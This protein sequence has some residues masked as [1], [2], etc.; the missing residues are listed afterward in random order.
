[1]RP[2]YYLTQQLAVEGVLHARNGGDYIL[3]G[4]F[5]DRAASKTITADIQIVRIVRS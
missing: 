4:L 1:V 5:T 3:E 2:L